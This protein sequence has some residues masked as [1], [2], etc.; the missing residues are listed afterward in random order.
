MLNE[1]EEKTNGLK[2]AFF[3]TEKMLYFWNTYN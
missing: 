1:P 3:E 2:G